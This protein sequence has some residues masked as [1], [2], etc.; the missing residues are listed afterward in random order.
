MAAPSA[1]DP[2]PRP[3]R[4]TLEDVAARA[5]VSRATASRVVN[6]SARVSEEA[7][8]AVEAAVAELGY[9]PNRAARSLVTRRRDAV[10][11]VV[12]ES[13]TRLFAEPFFAGLV[14]GVSTALRRTRTPLVLSSVPPDEPVEAT[15]RYLASHVDGVLLAS[16]R[17]EDPLLVRLERAGVPLVLIGRPPAAERR[18]HVDADNHDGAARAVSHLLARGRRRIATVSGPRELA[19]GGDRLDG[20]R[21]A[22]EQA[23]LVP[24]EGLVAEGDFS[25]E[26]GRRA[27]RTLLAR[28]PDLDAVFAASD[29]MALAAIEVLERSG[30]RVPRDVAV[31]GFDDSVLA[32]TSRPPLTS[33][34]Q[35]VEEL[36]DTA[37]ERLRTVMAG[38]PVPAATVLPTRLVVR[39]SA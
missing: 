16:L 19:S 14:R 32:G 26:S 21:A 29:L 23:G 27:T 34:H 39:E 6:R 18:V 4:V 11:L 1:A 38:G 35:P 24:D 30:H 37:V 3:E 9:A 7:R 28:R 13:E 8:R 17:S 10:G 33:V 31:V 12:A 22:L 20:Y 15:V 36:G 5:G 25:A 2:P